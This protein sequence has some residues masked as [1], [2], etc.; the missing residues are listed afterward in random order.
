MYSI[1]TSVLFSGCDISSGTLGGFNVHTFPTSKSKLNNAID[2]LYSKHSEYKIPEKWWEKD[3]WNER[4]YGFLESKIFYFKEYPEEMYY[5][6]F[7]GDSAMLEKS[8]QASIALRA[9]YHRER[10]RWLLS[11]D[12][13]INE[14]ARIEARFDK[15]IIKRLENYT[16]GRAR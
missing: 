2:T 4:G 8:T 16:Y 3:D 11:E 13:D 1:I 9:V 14:R 7:I 12:V 15:E 10:D 5:V 6:S